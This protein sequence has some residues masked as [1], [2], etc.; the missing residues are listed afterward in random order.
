MKQLPYVPSNIQ[1]KLLP[2]VP[3]QLKSAEATKNETSLTEPSNF[4][5][6]VSEP[7]HKVSELPEHQSR[8]L[9][10]I[11]ENCNWSRK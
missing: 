7:A 8:P 2:Y 1:M 3:S 4:M 9:I 10:T 11:L 5:K 6:Q